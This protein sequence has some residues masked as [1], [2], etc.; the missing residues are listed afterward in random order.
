MLR[1]IRGAVK[2]E[3]VIYLFL[4]NAGY[5]RSAEVKDEI[6][7]LHIEPIMNVAYRFQYNPCERLW[8]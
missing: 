4:D 8:G 6:K 2:D 7:K 1:E 5:H 3:T